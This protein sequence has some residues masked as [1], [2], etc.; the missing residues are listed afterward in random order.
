MMGLTAPIWQRT[1]VWHERNYIY[2]DGNPYVYHGDG[3]ALTVEFPGGRCRRLTELRADGKH[4]KM[5]DNFRQENPGILK[6]VAETR[7][8]H[9]SVT[10]NGFKIPK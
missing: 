5:P 1:M 8:P 10:R 2:V 7:K 6:N 4:I 3:D 9:Q